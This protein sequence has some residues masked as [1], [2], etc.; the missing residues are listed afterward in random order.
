M[1]STYPEGSGGFVEDILLLYPT[2]DARES[3]VGL[4]ACAKAP[5]QVGINIMTVIIYCGGADCLF[6]R[7]CRL[8]G[9]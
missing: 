5:A 1:L 3:L 6:C 4:W 7:Y 9:F 2:E 8:I